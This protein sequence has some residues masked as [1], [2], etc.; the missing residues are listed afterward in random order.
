VQLRE[1]IKTDQV[2]LDFQPEFDLHTR[3]VLGVEALVRWEHPHRGLLDPTEFVQLA[4][5][6]GVIEALG[7]WTLRAACQ[8]RAVWQAEM[9]AADFAVRVN[10]SPLQLDNPAFV[11]LVSVVLSA[12]GTQPGDLCLE[13]TERGEPKDAAT[14]ADVLL[15]LRQMGITIALDDFGVGRNGLLRL[16]ENLYDVIK[17]DQAFVRN[18]IPDSGDATIVAAI[19]RL[20]DDLGMDVVAEGIDSEVALAELIRLGCRKGQGFLLGEPM[21]AADITELLALDESR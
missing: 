20:G 5:T 12:T 15:G 8:Q 7:E 3:S 1:A 4:E 10:V 21:A 17:I 6:S 13:V 18:L 2:H 19:L 14:M 11:E 9:P 16:R